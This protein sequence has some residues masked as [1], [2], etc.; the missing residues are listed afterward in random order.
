[1][2]RKKPNGTPWTSEHQPKV[3]GGKRAVPKDLQQ[4]SN[5]TKTMLKGVINKHLWMTQ[6][7]LKEAMKNKTTP[8]IELVVGSII[9]KAVV[10]GDERRLDFIL[11][12]MIGKVTEQ[13]DI[14]S[15]IQRL[16]SLDEAEII[17]LSNEAITYLKAGN[18]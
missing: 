10:D 8:M 6:H 14:K 3:R 18:E 1:M 4:A 15:Y 9:H 13:V 5:L 17:N 7:Q 12:R 16:D 11:N 2:P